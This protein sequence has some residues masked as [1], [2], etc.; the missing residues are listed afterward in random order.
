[1]RTINSLLLISTASFILCLAAPEVSAQG[2]PGSTNTPQRQGG[3]QRQ[4]NFDPAQFQQRM[5]DRYRERL[6][7]TDD[8]EWKAIQPL[9][10]GVLDARMA[11]GTGGR[12]GFV[13]TRRGGTD[14]NPASP[15]A[16]QTRTPER[17]NPAAAELQKAI[18]S[19]ASPTEMKAAV[20][21]YMDY[22]KA[23]QADLD[24]AR[25]ALRVVLTSRQEGIA[26][27]SGLL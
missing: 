1:M 10:Q 22:R 24:K 9:I 7:I 21:K 5:M 6:E 11:L 3:R 15:T 17:S 14:G 12:G 23:K 27:L 13:R 19:K 20:T 16:V 2:D 4:G 26:V 8:A 18:D 25:E